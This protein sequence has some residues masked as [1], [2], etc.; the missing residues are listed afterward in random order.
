MKIDTPD[1]SAVGG[2]CLRLTGRLAGNLN[3]VSY[4]TNVNYRLLSKVAERHASSQ[5]SHSYH[6]TQPC[7]AIG[8]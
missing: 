1:A 4:Q 2:F 3:S 7:R 6:W 8:R 5:E